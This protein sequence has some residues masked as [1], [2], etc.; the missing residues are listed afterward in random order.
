MSDIFS[1]FGTEE[2][3][4]KGMSRDEKKEFIRKLIREEQ[5]STRAAFFNP[6]T[7]EM[8][9]LQD[10]ARELGEEQ[11]IEKI[12]D[13]IGNAE[14]KSI[15][16]NQEQIQSIMSK[17]KRGECTE[18]EMTILKMV[19]SSVSSSDH[20]Q[21]LQHTM[22]FIMEIVKF[23]QEKIHYEP[24][25]LDLLG[26][27]DILFTVDMIHDESLETSRFQS[28][29][30]SVLAEISSNIGEDI[31]S[32]WEKSCSS[33]PSNELIVLGLI[34]ALRRVLQRE[35]FKFIKADVI[36]DI[37]GLDKISDDED[38][39]ENGSNTD[40]DC[41]SNHNDKDMRNLLKE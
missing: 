28:G 7:G 8:I 15:C 30:P 25:L 21:F 40:D 2:D 18:E 31:L 35:D 22:S 27:L 41:E 5:P 12:I 19:M 6:V 9:N 33:V 17:F 20:T 10:L 1:K 23:S 32:T 34:A 38:Y 37:L 26:A 4:T 13:A 14:T 16:I 29:G 11:A 36:S 24:T 39:E 3:P